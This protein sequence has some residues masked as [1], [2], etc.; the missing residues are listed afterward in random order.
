MNPLKDPLKEPLKDI[1]F[2]LYKSAGSA[3]ELGAHGLL[4]WGKRPAGATVAALLRAFS[5]VYFKGFLGGSF[6]GIFQ[7]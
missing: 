4:G 3:V 7:G 1:L 6:R 2:R 5:C